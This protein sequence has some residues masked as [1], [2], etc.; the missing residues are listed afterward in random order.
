MSFFAK[1]V[2]CHVILAQIIW[3]FAG[4]TLS[5]QSEFYNKTIGSHEKS[6]F[7]G[8]DGACLCG[9]LGSG[10]FLH[11]KDSQRQEGCDA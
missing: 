7:N 5:L 8:L 10:E 3:C 4:I 1:N 9:S 6:D 2:F 11:C